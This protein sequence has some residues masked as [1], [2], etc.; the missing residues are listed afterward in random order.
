MLE[1]L[2]NEIRFWETKNEKKSLIY[3]MCCD[4]TK[5]NEISNGDKHYYIYEVCLFV[6]NGYNLTDKWEDT[7]FSIHTN[8]YC[9]NINC[10]DRKQ[11][12][13]LYHIIEFIRC[14]FENLRNKKESHNESINVFKRTAIEFLGT[15]SHI[16]HFN[17]NTTT[18]YNSQIKGILLLT[19][20]TFCR[21]PSPK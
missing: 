8:V 5:F 10:K 16:L 21:V 2:A 19:G 9:G 1:L 7:E 4:D 15:I 20:P 18:N 6:I 11:I 3:K 12:H 17:G 13:P 14:A